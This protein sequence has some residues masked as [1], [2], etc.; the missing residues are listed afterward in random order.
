MVHLHNLERT[1]KHLHHCV[2]YI[3]CLDRMETVHME[4]PVVFFRYLKVEI[5]YNQLNYFL[6][7]IMA[8][9]LLL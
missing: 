8:I 4:L 2:L 9:E 5:V 1:C 3:L 7:H 6:K